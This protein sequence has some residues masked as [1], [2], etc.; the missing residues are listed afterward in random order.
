MMKKSCLIVKALIMILVITLLCST[1]TACADTPVNDIELEDLP[2]DS[3]F[4]RV[5]DFQVKD[6]TIYYTG[7]SIAIGYCGLSGDE[8][9]IIINPYNN[10]VCE[11]QIE[12]DWIYFWASPTELCK[13]N[14]S[15][16]ETMEFYDISDILDSED[17]V[18][19]IVYDSCLYCIHYQ[20]EEYP[21][22]MDIV[23]LQ[24]MSCSQIACGALIDIVQIY[25]RYLYVRADNTEEETMSAL[26]RINLQSNDIKKVITIS[27]EASIQIRG[28]YIVSSAGWS[29][30]EIQ[31]INGTRKEELD[32]INPEL[33]FADEDALYIL[34]N[35]LYKV[36]YADYNQELIFEIDRW[37]ESFIFPY[38]WNSDEKNDY[39]FGDMELVH[40]KTHE[41]IQVVEP[42]LLQFS[43]EDIDTYYELFNEAEDLNELD[44]SFDGKLVIIEVESDETE[45]TALFE[46]EKEQYK[47]LIDNDIF[48]M[49]P[50]EVRYI[51]FAKD[52]TELIGCY[53]NSGE[54]AYVQHINFYIYN[55]E[56]KRL[57][58]SGKVTGSD[59]PDSIYVG[60]S[61]KGKGAYGTY[62]IDHFIK[63]LI[64]IW[65][66]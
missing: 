11:F 12:D 20:D 63:E 43:Q 15:D 52:S 18:S 65:G 47:Q 28:E 57:I 61:N 1:F 49:S 9:G 59:P 62:P 21:D 66:A 51:V 53:T 39:F 41:T 34:G 6:D 40:Y 46:M 55:A 7:E 42:V 22:A 3:N 54:Q 24:D 60:P 4:T 13:M 32:F 58:Y 31:Q 16:H 17:I 56:T 27:P 64:E 45:E 44:F 23:D 29:Y 36:D 19:W 25:D 50:E 8:R 48:A 2:L 26:M 14:L 38:C 10:P 35:D 37:Y 5:T 33:F 30:L